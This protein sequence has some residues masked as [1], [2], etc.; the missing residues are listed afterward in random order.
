MTGK[1]HQILGLTT[2][3]ATYLAFAPE[4]YGPATFFS[5]LVMCYFSALLP[6]LDRPT[7]KLWAD[8]PMGHEM[9][10]V[11]DPLFK[12]RNISH[13]ILGVAIFGFLIQLF[14]HSFPAYWGVDTNLLSVVSI[15]S[16]SSHVISDMFTVDGVPLLFPLKRMF[17]LP[18]K[19]FDG[20]RI[21][22]G[23]WFENLVI[24]PLLNLILVVIIVS[25]WDLIKTI[26]FK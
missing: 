6:D 26:I 17:G 7:A 10:H 18:P 8:I 23:K 11:V 24:F 5:V 13:S 3:V 21:E 9:G 25:K 12:H 14:F 15:V 22:T 19:P 4:S 20:I 1:T 16:Y 2:G